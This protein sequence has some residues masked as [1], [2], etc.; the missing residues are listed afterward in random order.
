MIT[1]HLRA[2]ALIPVLIAGGAWVAFSVSEGTAV[3]VL[4]STPA[5]KLSWSRM[6]MSVRSKDTDFTGLR[7]QPLMYATRAGYVSPP[8]SAAR[9]APP[10]PN[11]RLVGIL[12]V[13]QKPARALLMP[14]TGSARHVKSGDELDGW[15]VEAV[16]ASRVVLAFGSQRSEIAKPA[17]TTGLKLIRAPVSSRVS[18]TSSTATKAAV[19][20]DSEGRLLAASGSAAPS[21]NS[22][23]RGKAALL[24]TPRLFQPPPQ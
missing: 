10:L 24:A 22:I 15:K 5:G 13:P 7:D 4:L 20:G 14:P 12:I 11:Y 19:P 16:E 2:I 17:G 1:R 9:S 6:D 18:S 3:R 23:P 8:P 21:S